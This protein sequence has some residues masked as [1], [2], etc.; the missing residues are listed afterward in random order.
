MA[1]GFQVAACALMAAP[2]LGAVAARG[3]QSIE[4]AGPVRVVGP[5]AAAP[6]TS[7]AVCPG[8]LTEQCY[9]PAATA[10]SFV[11][12]GSFFDRRGRTESS[13][14]FV[15]LFTPATAGRYQI[16]ALS[17]VCSRLNAVFPSAGVVLTNAAQPI[18]PTADQLLRL[19]AL[20]I[21]TQ[22]PTTPT[23]VDL[24][25]KSIILESGQAAWLVLNFPDAADSVFIG[26]KSETDA[27]GTASDHACDFMTRDSGEYWYRPDARY[28]P[29]DWM[30][31][32]YY[33]ALPAAPRSTWA[34]VKRLYR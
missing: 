16:D 19:Q 13:H 26:V 1:I 5:E 3:G 27:A 21:T 9:D 14:Y 25:G 17:F 28:S 12:V 33:D 4:A 10:T 29:Y 20:A 11:N 31:A 18:F 24:T 23:C 2:A 7:A 15:K 8:T 34:T 32:A 30:I 6:A 22:A